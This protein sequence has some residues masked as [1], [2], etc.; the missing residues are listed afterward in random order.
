MK[1]K[2]SKIHNIEFL[3]LELTKFSFV[4]Q[5][6]SSGMPQNEIYSYPTFWMEVEKIVKSR[7]FYQYSLL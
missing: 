4:Y 6:E 1:K 7:D 2:S 5:T 3:G